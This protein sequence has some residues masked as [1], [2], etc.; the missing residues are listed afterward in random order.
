MV[1]IAKP[2][3]RKELQGG[4][5]WH[6]KLEEVGVPLPRLLGSGEVEGYPFAVYERLLGT[7]LEKIY[8]TLH[9]A[10]RKRFAEGVA[11]IQ[12]KVGTLPRALGYGHALSY[13]DSCLAKFSSWQDVLTGIL[14]RTEHELAASGSPNIRYVALVRKEIAR[15]EEYLFAVA[16]VAFLYDTN[17]RNVIIHNGQISGIIDVDEVTFGDPLLS[18][19]FTKT[20]LLLA[21]EDTGFVECWCKALDCTAVD[22]GIIDLYA[23]VYAVRF[24]GTLG[25]TPQWEPKPDN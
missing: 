1:R 19:G 7:D 14:D 25:Q 20:Y 10:D 16:P 22:L 13:D 9:E 18:L 23:L 5:Y 15:A 8:S 2:S 4:L 17:I 11:G 6:A 3:R 12:R 24:M 21:K